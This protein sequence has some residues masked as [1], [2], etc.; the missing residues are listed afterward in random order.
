MKYKAILLVIFLHI[1][2][3]GQP[4]SI[5]DFVGNWTGNWTNTTFGSTGSATMSLTSNT[6]NMTAQ[7]ILDMNGNVLGGADPGP[8]T[9][10]GTYTDTEFTVS[11]TT[12][13]FGEFTLSVDN[14]G[15]L[16][17]QGINV[18]NTFIER[19]DFSGTGTPTLITINYVVTFS[20]NAGG[21]NAVGVL[22]FNTKHPLGVEKI[23]DSNNSDFILDQ[24]Y[25]NP[26]NPNTN[27]NFSLPEEIHVNL[28][29][30]NLTGQLVNQL[31]NQTLTRG[32][33]SINWDGR[34]NIGNP[35]SGGIYIYKL[36]VGNNIFTKKM[37][38]MK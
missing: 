10:D 34:D 3:F 2:V 4:Y 37:I 17:G 36:Q 32:E 26:F 16:S 33:Y 35:L 7:M 5:D 21:G 30:Y 14:Q 25:P 13:L 9:L 6:T 15:M 8:M 12:D 18:P 11:A 28:S 1:T 22:L 23:N 27:I 19:V 20:A 31:V 29:I 24:N 38:L